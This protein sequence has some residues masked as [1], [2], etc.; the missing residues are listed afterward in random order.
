MGAT[1]REREEP[2]APWVAL[3]GL[4]V[5]VVV[6][7]VAELGGRPRQSRALGLAERVVFRPLDSDGYSTLHFPDLSFRVPFGWDRYRARLI[8]AFPNEPDA[9]LIAINAFMNK[10]FS[11]KDP[12]AWAKVEE[13][14]EELRRLDPDNPFE[15]WYRAWVRGALERDRVGETEAY[16]ELLQRDDLTPSY[17][18]FILGYRAWGRRGLDRD[19]ALRDYAEAVRLG[20]A[21]WETH[22]NYA[23]LLKDAGR[24]E[25][26]V[27][28]A[29]LAL[30]LD[31]YANGV[32]ATFRQVLRLAG[33]DEEL[34][35]V[36]K[37]WCR[38]EG[39][40]RGQAGL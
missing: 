15:S 24:M 8:E 34:V 21:D 12:D 7:P 11:D 40:G 33:R 16:T 37:N 19:A 10:G 23:W 31:P 3:I 18:S 36:T 13:L 27:V 30:A 25:E 32:F 17:R 4:G 35:N 9:I 22:R 26:A 29:G 20:A 39:G 6:E 28:Q 5:A 38:G 14:F 1:S 2:A